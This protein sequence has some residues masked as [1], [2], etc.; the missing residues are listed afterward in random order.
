[1]VYRKRWYNIE[2]SEQ[3]KR[4]V[5]TIIK[6][7]L[8]KVVK[9]KGCTNEIHSIPTLFSSRQIHCFQSI[10][11]WWMYRSALCVHQPT[12]YLCL[13]I[14]NPFHSIMWAKKV[15][16]FSVFLFFIHIFC[17]NTQNATRI[18]CF[19]YRKWL[20]LLESIEII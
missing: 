18:I 19:T 6:W 1:M 16:Q 8:R 5:Y 4:S 17:F 3:T 9:M 15:E 20:V 2:C 14:L 13:V 7:Y 12:I 11:L 10:C